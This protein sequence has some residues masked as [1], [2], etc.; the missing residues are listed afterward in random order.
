MIGRFQR[1]LRGQALRVFCR[2][3][4]RQRTYA[5]KAWLLPVASKVQA[6]SQLYARQYAGC[7]DE[8]GRGFWS[9]FWHWL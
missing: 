5:S 3:G 6:R 9:Q 4:Y 1:R 2:G 8:L 7:K